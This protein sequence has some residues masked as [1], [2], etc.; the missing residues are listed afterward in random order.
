METLEGPIK[1]K[2]MKSIRDSTKKNDGIRT[3][4][5][6][7]F[8]NQLQLN[9]L[10]FFLTDKDFAHSE[11]D[12][13]LIENDNIQKG[14]LQDVTNIEDDDKN[15]TDKIF[16]EYEECLEGVHKLYSDVKTYQKRNTN[17]RTWKD[18]N[19]HTMFLE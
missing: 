12:I 1:K 2:Y 19:K 6:V 10:Q 8:F 7:E 3:E 13:V 5:L 9:Y 18:F 16:D 11:S 4:I 17:P 15:E 14:I